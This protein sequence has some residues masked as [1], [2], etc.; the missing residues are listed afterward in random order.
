MLENEK[1]TVLLNR[2]AS[3]YIQNCY[4]RTTSISVLGSIIFLHVLTQAKAFIEHDLQFTE[5]P[6]VDS[7][8]Y[9]YF[10]D[11]TWSLPKKEKKKGSRKETALIESY[12]TYLILPPYWKPFK[13]W[14]SNSLLHANIFVILHSRPWRGIWR[15][16]GRLWNLCHIFKLALKIASTLHSWSDL[17][18]SSTANGGDASLIFWDTVWS[19][20]LKFQ[21]SVWYCALVKYLQGIKKKEKKEKR[22]TL[23]GASCRENIIWRGTFMLHHFLRV[24]G[25]RL[26][27]S[28]WR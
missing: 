20:T 15:A 27:N 6:T 5:G 19:Q 22:L 26:Q 1:H 24:R 3:V 14:A 8:H 9:Y 12:V 13:R 7:G 25:A 17:D 16:N 4:C 10:V 2:S 18:L 28:L 21:T 11:I 23:L